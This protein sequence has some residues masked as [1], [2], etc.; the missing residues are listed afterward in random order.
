MWMLAGL[1]FVG[2]VLASMKTSRFDGELVQ[3][4]HPYRRLMSHIM[5][6]KSEATVY[7]DTY[8]DAAE[9]LRYLAD[10]EGKF[11]ADITHCLVGAGFVGLSQVPSMNR[12]VAGRRLY[13][14]RWSEISFSMKRKRRDRQAK[15]ANVKLKLRAGETFRMLCDR[16]QSEIVV[17]RSDEVTREDREYSLL[18]ILPRPLLA[19]AI[20][21]AKWL[22][23]YNLAPRQ[24]IADDPLYTSIFCGN[25]G[26]LGMSAGYHHLFEWGHCP[27]FM[28]VGG[29]EERPVVTNGQLSVRPQLHIRWSYDER[30]D[31]G[32]NAGRGIAA[33]KNALEH[34][35]EYLGCLR[36]DG[37]DARPLDTPSA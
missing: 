22:D 18:T 12:F 13:Q 2:W 16:M 24:L 31:D 21:A 8:V 4:L 15:I 11:T 28:M 35:F 20:T 17:E 9:L 37:S 23:Y 3:P 34:P 7:F 25:L 1:V 30:I 27:I 33:V 5:D 29:L 6:K 14:R 10:T 36:D 26:S 32:L 19:A